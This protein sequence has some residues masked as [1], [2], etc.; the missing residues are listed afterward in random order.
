[1]NTRTD[2]EQHANDFWAILWP[3]L[4]WFS[5]L[6]SKT[7]T[8]GLAAFAPSSAAMLHTTP[9]FPRTTAEEGAPTNSRMRA[10][11]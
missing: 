6:Y 9:C 1:M 2:N 4:F 11:R 8:N 7:I 10:M 5:L 3:H